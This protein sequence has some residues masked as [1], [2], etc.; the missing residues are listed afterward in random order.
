[1]S[2]LIV[3]K[4]KGTTIRIPHKPCQFVLPVKQCRLGNNAS[5]SFHFV[6]TGDA[7]REFVARFCVFLLVEF[8]LQLVCRRRLYIIDI[9]LFHR[10]DFAR[11]NL[12]TIRRPTDVCRVIVSQRTIKTEL[13]FF[14]GGSLLHIDVIILDICFIF[15]VGREYGSRYFLIIPIHPMTLPGRSL[16]VIFLF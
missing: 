10:A 9:T 12:F 14:S 4:S 13:S 3:L 16:R 6:D 7:E 5:S 11:S 1:M 2:T 15:M 8:W